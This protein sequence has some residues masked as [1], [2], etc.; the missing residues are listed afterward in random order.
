MYINVLKYIKYIKKK[1]NFYARKLLKIILLC[2]QIIYIYNV[3]K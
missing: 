3:L 1:I 2:N